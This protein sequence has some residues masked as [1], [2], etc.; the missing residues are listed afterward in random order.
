MKTGWRKLLSPR[1][2]ASI[3]HEIRH[4]GRD[5]DQPDVNLRRFIL[6]LCVLASAGCAVM[7]D[8][9]F[10]GFEWTR[11]KRAELPVEWWAAGFDRVQTYCYHRAGWISNACA[12]YSAASCLI[13]AERE[14]AETPKWLADHERRH[15]AGW[16]HMNVAEA[17]P[18]IPR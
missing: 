15:C 1:L 10:D 8:P 17:K 5:T 11:S 2:R 16:D 4:A 13:V 3:R 9:R 6:V 14:E 18:G 7:N 12:I